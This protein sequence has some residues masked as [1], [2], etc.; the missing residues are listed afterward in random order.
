M[1]KLATEDFFVG[2]EGLACDDFL[3]ELEFE[4]FWVELEDFL[5]EDFFFSEPEGVEDDFLLEGEREVDDFLAD[6][7]DDFFADPDEVEADDFFVLGDDF[8]AE[9]DCLLLFFISS[10]HFVWPKFKVYPSLHISHLFSSEH[11]W[12]CSIEHLLSSA[13]IIPIC[14]ENKTMNNILFL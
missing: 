10:R 9:L 5:A 1:P 14:I 2:P 6:P 12:Q 8:C 11:F 7:K 13:K 3:E 4:D